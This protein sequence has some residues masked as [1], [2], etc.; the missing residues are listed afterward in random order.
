MENKNYKKIINKL[1]K[2]IEKNGIPE[3]IKKWK[4]PELKYDFK[5][6]DEFHKYIFKLAKSYDKHTF[7][8]N[9]KRETEYCKKHNIN[10]DNDRKKPSI[11][12]LKNNILHLKFYHYYNDHNKD[13]GKQLDQWVKEV[14]HQIDKELEKV[15]N[16]IIIDLSQHSGGNMWPAIRAMINI[17]G[18]TTLLRFTSEKNWINLVNHKEKGGQFMTNELKFKKPI[19]IVVSE[20][21]ASSGE[22]IAASFKGRKNTYFYGHKTNK[23][24]GFLSSNQGFFIDDKKNLNLILTISLIQSVDKKIYNKEILR[25]KKYDN[26]IKAII[27]KY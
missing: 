11:K 20:K 22:I 16:A 25:V 15:L 5:N 26:P 27:D 13:W 24:G 19:H 10:T 12:R 17:Y 4:K 23:S 14:K 6:Y 2:T 21:T 18:K 1:I 8:I 9:Q 7:I 3:K